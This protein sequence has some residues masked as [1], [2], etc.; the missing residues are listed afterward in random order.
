MLQPIKRGWRW[1]G[2]GLVYKREW[3][4]E[5]GTRSLLDVT[6]DV[7]RS[8]VSGIAEY[9]GFTFE[10]CEDYEDKWLPTLDTNLRV[11]STNQVDYKFYQ[12]PTTANTT[13]RMTSAMGENAKMQCLSNDLVRRLL[14]TKEELP[15]TYRSEVMEDYGGETAAR[16]VV[17]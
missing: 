15:S 12:K 1:E 8:T 7:L 16:I 6:V 11:N 3:E 9:L 4:I 13:V 17:C 2:G 14:N 5:D 10:T